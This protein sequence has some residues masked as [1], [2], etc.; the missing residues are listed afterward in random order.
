MTAS[1]CEQI[2]A[3]FATAAAGTV[4]LGSRIY[5]DREQ[6]VG[7]GE[8]PTTQGVLIIEPASET[9]DISTTTE[10]L[11]TT[12]TITA[13]LYINGAPLSTISDPI[14]VDLHNRIM[15]STALRALV[16]SVYPSGRNWD[17]EAG[18]LG[19]VRSTYTVTYR[20]SLTDLTRQ[21]P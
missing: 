18:D 12:L 15:A 3:A 5:R 6:A 19:A 16:I 11:T 20:T 21:L 13:D 2:L 10:T 7:R 14:R 9:D 8:I 17:P 4:G 1:R